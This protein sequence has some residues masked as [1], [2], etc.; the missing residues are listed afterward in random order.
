MLLQAGRFEEA[1]S[2]YTEISRCVPDDAETWFMLGGINGHLGRFD[3]AVR[4]FKRSTS[5]A[6][7]RAEVHLHLGLVLWQ[8]GRLEDAADSLRRAIQ[9]NPN[10]AGAVQHYQS[11]SLQLSRQQTMFVRMCGNL[12]ICVPGSIQLMTPYVLLEQE[13]W[14]EDE[15]H[16]VR[17]FVKP[18]MKVVDVGANYG[19]YTLTMASLVGHTG[20]VWAFEP[21]S[22]TASCLRRSIERN[23]LDNVCLVQCALS[24]HGGTTK[25]MLFG[26]SELNAISREPGNA[27]GETVPLS[28]L[29]AVAIEHYWSDIA[30]MK[31]DAEGEELNILRGGRQFLRDQSPLIMFEIMHDQTPN[32]DLVECFRSL[33]YDPYRLIP[34]LNL[35]LPF[36]PST[37]VD[38]SQLNLFCCK[39]DRAGLLETQGLLVTARTL[40][41]FSRD[42]GTQTGDSW[43]DHLSRLPYAR[44]WLSHWQSEVSRNP[45]PGWEYHRDAIACFLSSTSAGI[46][47]GMSVTLLHKAMDEVNAAVK[48][49]CTPA[50]LQTLARIAWEW[51]LRSVAVEALGRLLAY[52]DDDLASSPEEPFLAVSRRYEQIDPSDSLLRWYRAAWLEMYEILSFFSS[53]SSGITALSRLDTLREIGCDCPQMERRRQLVR[54]KHGLQDVPEY[55]PLLVMANDEN[56]NPRFWSESGS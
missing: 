22:A 18:G 40:A 11:V 39:S 13:D 52:S 43:L 10:N 36:E 1:G 27:P 56:R 6:P 17:R 8:L 32:L 48:L 47:A 5:I 45:L 2:V 16:F 15:I 9:L 3:E 21:A 51:G 31:L 44:K 55:S 23:R 30:F 24:D 35:L 20:K 25:L 49:A 50:R 33:G 28:T 42:S 14:F 26:N 7:D 37:P 46:A 41:G 19:V 53:Y 29:D 4:Y 54:L 38:P 34:G 12:D